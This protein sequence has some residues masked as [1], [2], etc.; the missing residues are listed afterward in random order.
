VSG[1]RK[2]RVIRKWDDFYA[3]FPRESVFVEVPGEWAPA[4]FSLVR[5]SKEYRD[6]GLIVTNIGPRSQ[7]AKAGM[8]RGDVLLRYDGVEVDSTNTLKRLTM[9]YSRGVASSKAVSIDAVRGSDDVS[10]EV[11]KGPL[12]IT[13][14]PSLYRIKRIG[15][16]R[17]KPQ[18]PASHETARV[19]TLTVIDTLE[20]AQQ[21]DRSRTVLIEVPGEVARQIVSL[22]NT[23]EASGA[24]KAKN[25]AKALLSTV[26]PYAE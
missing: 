10:F 12:G 18:G 8:A 26:N 22:M 23:L 16:L 17:T 5:I 19:E 7:A 6:N 3:P 15:V 13:V 24:R 9:G 25:M 1:R 14:T 4:I 21:C 11:A 20:S 2:I